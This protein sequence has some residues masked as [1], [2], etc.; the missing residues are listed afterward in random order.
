MT[1]A[2]PLLPARGTAG[3]VLALALARPPTLAAG[4]L[5]CIDG[6][7][8]SGKTTLAA[9]LAALAPQAQVVHMDDL[10]EG[11]TGLPHVADQLETILRPLAHGEP[12]S[13]RRF[14]WGADRFAETVTVDPGALLVI[15]GVGAGS[16]IGADLAT[17]TVWV[18]A[19]AELRLHR[20]LERDGVEVRTQWETWMLA[21]AALFARE[22]TSARADIVVDGTGAT[23][24]RVIVEPGT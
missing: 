15:E 3:L 10:Y 23:P 16:R 6:P 21:E 22:G 1:V 5:V 12:G 13:Y 14:D 2:L 7:A 4:R 20:G 24:P 8:G 18:T 9:E 17:V 19:P 11:W